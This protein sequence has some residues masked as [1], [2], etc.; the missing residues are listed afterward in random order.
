[1]KYWITLFLVFVV[2]ALS[3]SVL[4]ADAGGDEIPAK[5][6]REHWSCME[7]AAL[8]AKY[9]PLN[10]FP[11]AVEIERRELAAMLSAVLEK[12]HDKCAK[13]GV[14]AVSREELDRIAVL[15]G[16][17]KKELT[18]FEGYSIRREAIERI[19]AKP[20]EKEPP[21][22]YKVGVGGFLRPEGVG[23]LHLPDFSYAPG[24]GEGR[25]L[26]RVKPYAYWHPADWLDI[27]AE[28]QGYGFRGGRDQEAN[29][30][31]LYQGFVEAKAPGV[32]MAALKGGRQEFIYGSTF[33]LGS[34]SFYE[35]LVFDA[36]RLRLKPAEPFSVD[37]LVGTY[38]PPFSAGLKG[39][40]AGVYATYGF[41]EGNAVEA[42]MFRDTGSTDH[43][44]GE[45][46]AVWGVRW[47]AKAGPLS[48]ELEP[49]YE[50]GRQLNSA[51]GGNDRIDAYGGHLD[52]TAESVLAGYNNKFFVSY[53]MGSG[54]K[55]AANGV[56][57]AREFRNPAND[58]SL[59]GDMNVIGDLSGLTVNGRHA[60]GL[61]IYTLG[62]GCDLA[63]GL[64]FSATGH[65]FAADQA[66]TGFSRHL[67]AETDFTLTYNMSEDLSLILG[68]DRFFT[69][70]F[71]ENAAGSDRDIHYGYAM[72]QFNL[73]KTKP[74][75]P[76][77]S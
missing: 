23:G 15:H 33:I 10:K 26:Y 37:L 16:A 4:F 59:V 38:A 28:G 60:S 2:L 43:H 7:I 71:F 48:V 52:V 44:V 66:E 20:E 67:G 8:A 31:S 68:Y 55:D 18:E 30:F 27:H 25:F 53:A 3:S 11:D 19:L 63:K 65:Y 35:G 76:R 77:K 47:T 51:G 45:Y 70:K 61:R 62:W 54:S 36:A 14:E 72:L 41:S 34:N 22:E 39:N 29:K 50:S 49:V 64:N 73:S 32:D 56:T 40:L 1:M 69:G 12:V 21:F 74:K 6:G 17:L 46:L 9:A 5:V 13:E 58:T 24:R 75:V 42:Y 57:A